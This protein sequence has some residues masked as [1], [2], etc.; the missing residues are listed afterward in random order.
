MPRCMKTYIR[1]ALLTG[2]RFALGALTSEGKLAQPLGAQMAKLPVG[3][4][5]AKVLLAAGPLGCAAEAAAVVAMTS[6]DNVFVSPACVSSPPACRTEAAAHHGAIAS[7][8]LAHV[9]SLL[10][11]ATP[12]AVNPFPHLFVQVNLGLHCSAK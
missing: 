9:P 5:Y 1:R 2:C 12:L 6:S 8:A 10:I 7:S 4:M 3:P 11:H